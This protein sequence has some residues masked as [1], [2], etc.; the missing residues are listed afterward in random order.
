MSEALE[1]S[2]LDTLATEIC[3]LRRQGE[4]AA[5]SYGIEIG[6]RLT[7]AKA[8]VGHGNWGKWL[9]TEVSYSQSQAELYMKAFEGYGQ[10][11]LSLYGEAVPK[12]IED[13]GFTKAVKL[14]AIPEEER[15]EFA[16]AVSAEDLSTRELDKA[17]RE[18]KQQ[19]EDSLK[20]YH[21]EKAYNADLK[22]KLEDAKAE[23][24]RIKRE[25]EELAARPPET[26]VQPPT[27]E[28]L[29]QIRAEEAAKLEKEKEKLKKQL[30]RAE[31]TAKDAAAKIEQAEE[32]ARAAA[33]D[34]IA[35][36][37]K[38]KEQLENKLRR[39]EADL[40][41]ADAETVEFRAHYEA[42]QEEFNRCRAIIMKADRDKAAKLRKALEAF[43]DRGKGNL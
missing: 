3:V 23:S 18:Y 41:T 6:R 29:E 36:L 31:A 32:K 15:E 13:L 28:M 19:A 34:E 21:D 2:K 4:I 43:L 37:T 30:E 9:E 8:L 26:I 25:M 12:I 10:D 33:E 39:A 22:K 24:D 27:E 14:L 11:Q 42:L 7:E 16:E 40:K 1:K 20:A 35:T 5:L 17:I 38:Q